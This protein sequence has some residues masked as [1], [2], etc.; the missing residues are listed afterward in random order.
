M[1]V[2]HIHVQKVIPEQIMTENDFS[3]TRAVCQEERGK[4]MS[5]NEKTR[6]VT[7]SGFF[8]SRETFAGCGMQHFCKSV[9]AD[10]KILYNVS[11]G[12]LVLSP[13]K[14]PLFL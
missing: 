2:E 11:R 10:S 7:A 3:V 8:V 14:R 12:Q 4:N 5:A 6:R 9:Q 1:R 13:G